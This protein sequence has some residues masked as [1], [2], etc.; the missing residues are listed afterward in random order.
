MPFPPSGNAQST[1]PARRG[2]RKCYRR[3]KP[4]SVLPLH[5]RKRGGANAGRGRLVAA[6]TT[7]PAAA[8]SAPAAAAAAARAAFLGPGLVHGQR[9]SSHLLAVQPGDRRLRLLV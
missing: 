2:Q 5:G 8:E 4:C 9:A 1:L 3:Q 7:T 6:A